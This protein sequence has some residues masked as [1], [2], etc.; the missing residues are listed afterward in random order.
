MNRNLSLL[1]FR[2]TTQGA[3]LEIRVWPRS[4]EWNEMLKRG[5]MSLLSHPGI[6]GFT[7][8]CGLVQD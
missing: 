5:N 2:S 4:K 6:L 8:L 7:Y 1:C 3:V